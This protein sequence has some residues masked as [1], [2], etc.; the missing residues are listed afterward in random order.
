M[1]NYHKVTD[2]EFCTLKTAETAFPSR[3]E[4]LEAETQPVQFTATY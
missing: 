3:Q 1:G 4:E 2:G